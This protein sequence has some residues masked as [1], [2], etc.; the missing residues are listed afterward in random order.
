[1]YPGVP[2]QTPALI[3]AEEHQVL[4]TVGGQS[5]NFLVDTRASYSVLTEAPGPL[6]PQSASIM[7]LSGRAKRY[8]F[9][10]SLSYN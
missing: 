3:T 1:M 2:T 7:G 10:Y 5:V 8:Y 6:S 4:V 9:S